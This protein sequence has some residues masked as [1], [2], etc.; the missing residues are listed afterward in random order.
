[1]T[2]TE[3]GTEPGEAPGDSAAGGARG[4]A[5]QPTRAPLKL[6]IPT[7]SEVTS[8]RAREALEAL[9]ESADWELRWSGLSA[10]EDAVRRAVLELYRALGR[11]PSHA[12]L[13]ARTALDE[14]QIATVLARLAARDLVVLEGSGGALV[15]A[16]PL[17]ERDTGHRVEIDGHALNAM[18]AV[19]AL[20]VGAMYGRDARVESSC[21]ACGAPITVE[22]G[23]GGAALGPASPAEPVVWFGLDYRTGCAATSLCTVIVFFCGAAHFERWRGDNPGAAGHRLSLA[24]AFEAAKALFGNRLEAAANAG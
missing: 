5:T 4:A 13:G 2:G 9:V 6:Q 24:E 17:S 15:G 3:P 8:E 22:L 16:Y 10:V 7:W 18:C 19:D 23:D 11:A 1:M 21:R 20:G 14:A 12:E